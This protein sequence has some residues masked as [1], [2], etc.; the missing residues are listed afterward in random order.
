M[1]HLVRVGR[2]QPQTLA[3]LNKKHLFPT[4]NPFS[5]MNASY[6]NIKT[7]IDSQVK[8]LSEILVVDE[9]IRDILNHQ[10][11]ESSITE[12][13]LQQVLNKCKLLRV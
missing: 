9:N 11:D 7:F 5:S 12:E 3:H 1:S 10:G 4:S 6:T 2:T 13:K 8:I